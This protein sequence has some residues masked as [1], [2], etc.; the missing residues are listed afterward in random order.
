M[1]QAS[2]YDLVRSDVPRIA[3][4]TANAISSVT[5]PDGTAPEYEFLL[6]NDGEDVSEL[7]WTVEL[8]RVADRAGEASQ[9]LEAP[10]AP[11]LTEI[12]SGER[13]R[14]LLRLTALREGSH[15]LHV[16]VETKKGTD[17]GLNNR[18]LAGKT[19][20]VIVLPAAK[21]HGV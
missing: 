14:V 2:K 17:S 7:V 4:R 8:S 9:V 20:T 10:Q 15:R 12:A 6:E 13:R 3:L 5:V 16:K 1:L 11:E 19:V 21:P 18:I